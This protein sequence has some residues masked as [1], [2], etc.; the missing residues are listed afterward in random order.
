MKVPVFIMLLVTML[1]AE[2]QPLVVA[3]HEFPPCVVIDDTREGQD[4][5]SGF[6]IELFK[7][8]A[9]NLGYEY[10]WYAVPDFTDIIHKLAEDES[11]YDVGVAGISITKS[12]EEL[13]DFSHPYLNSGLSVMIKTK[14]NPKVTSV[15]T[16]FF[17]NSWQAFLLFAGFLLACSIV[18]W[19]LEK[20]VPSFNDNWIKGIGD[21]IYWTVTTMTTV[22]YGD[23]VPVRP[24]SRIFAMIVMF[25]GICV[26]FPYF[27]AGMGQSMNSAEQYEIIGPSGL[28]GKSVAVIR[29]STSEETMK[30]Y[31]ATLHPTSSF[32]ECR[33]L[34][35][36]GIVKA[37]IYDTPA[38]KHF[39]KS[40]DGYSTAGPVFDKQYYG[41]AFKQ[42]S[43][44]REEF[45][46]EL[47]RV[48]KTEKFKDIQKK[49]F[50]NE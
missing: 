20:G 46:Q 19:L 11:L 26:V 33:Q 47:L 17:V 37:V 6:D 39:I 28:K 9:D 36:R 34:L 12:R 24:L 22:G 32:D 8:V 7:M 15:I 31:G 16:G 21:G 2:K 5:V 4:K 41:F 29:G 30:G 40:N 45:N 1:F 27:V 10:N 13:I 43:P 49:W 25:V 3:V 23:K 44:L 18:M 48:M 38:V 14:S 42:G 35:D 50:G